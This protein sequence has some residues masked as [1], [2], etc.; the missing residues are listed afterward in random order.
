MAI[1]PAPNQSGCTAEKEPGDS[2]RAIE[3]ID[4]TAPKGHKEIAQGKAKRRP[5][6]AA[7]LGTPPE[8]LCRIS[9]KT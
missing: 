4:P 7:A 3:V 9:K 6:D 5:G 2:H 8:L 1:N